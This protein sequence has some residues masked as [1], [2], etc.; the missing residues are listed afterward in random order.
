MDAL[1][2]KLVVKA[3]DE[4]RTAAGASAG[5]ASVEDATVSELVAQYHGNVVALRTF[6]SRNAYLEHVTDV[7]PFHIRKSPMPAPVYPGLRIPL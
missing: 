4:V 5:T 1:E 7:R 2:E 6:L 3:A